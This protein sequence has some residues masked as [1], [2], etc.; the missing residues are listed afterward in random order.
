VDIRTFDK[1][2]AGIEDLD[3]PLEEGVEEMC[4]QRLAL[5]LKPY[6]LRALS[7]WLREERAPMGTSRHLWLKVP[8]PGD[9][10]G[11]ECWVSPS[12]FQMFISKSPIATQQ[13][14][15]THGGCGWQALEMGMGKTAVAIAGTLFNPPPEG[16]RAPRPWKPM[17]PND[18]MGE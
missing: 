13:A 11:V 12:L 10:P 15:G 6:Q 3:R 9:Q 17:D 7:F 14:L 5:R 1:I 16:W 4:L 2:M 18:Y 8:L